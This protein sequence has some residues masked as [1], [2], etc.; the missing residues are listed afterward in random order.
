MTRIQR[1]SLYVPSP[2]LLAEWYQALGF[3]V[4]KRGMVYHIAIGYSDLRLIQGEQEA[5]FHVAFHVRAPEFD[6]Y[7]A[8]L[9]ET[10]DL[11]PANPDGSFKREFP[12]WEA[13]SVYAHDPCGNI[14]EW[15][16][17]PGHAWTDLPI[18]TPAVTGIAEVGIPVPDVGAYQHR[19]GL[20]LP[21]WK[22][23]GEEFAIMGGTE[24]LILLV[25][26][27]RGWIPTGRPAEF[28]P[29]SGVLN[30]DGKRVNFH[31]VEGKITWSR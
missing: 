28:F 2:G 31:S 30:H 3:G 7:L 20:F 26:E 22:P 29:C 10:I 12:S 23:G 24:G 4:R 25:K 21:E 13:H 19:A 14:V 1:L 5:W 16:A 27:G 15:I 6:G 11:L 18:P 17:R 8:M 9:Q